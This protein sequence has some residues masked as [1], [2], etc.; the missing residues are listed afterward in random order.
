MRITILGTCGGTE[1]MPGRKHTAIAIEHAGGLYWLDAGEGCSRTG[2]LS[3][4]D[5]FSTRAI[6]VSHRHTDHIGGLLNLIYTL[7]KLD[8]RTDKKQNKLAGRCVELF[9]PDAE[10]REVF[11]QLL[12]VGLAH[13]MPSF[14]VRHSAY[15][16]GLFYDD[17]SLRVTARHNLHMG[18][19]SDNQPWRSFSC[20]VEAGRKKLVFSGDLADPAELGPL[21]NGA[22]LVLT[23]VG[24]FEPEQVC[25]YLSRSAKEFGR[26]ALIHFGRTMLADVQGQARKARA[27]LGDRVI[28]PEDGTT[29]EI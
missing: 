8:S 24:H 6:F 18:E 9:T 19:P 17:G 2:Y 3:G 7:Y 23:E 10:L 14:D 29:L 11:D 26:V 25:T 13:Y 20:A 21:L 5:F 28:I 12:S 15:Q 27:L 1:P 4:L 22:D 16:D